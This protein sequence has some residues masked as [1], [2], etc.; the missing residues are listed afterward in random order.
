M[1]DKRGESGDSTEGISHAA[2]EVGGSNGGKVVNLPLT[3]LYEDLAQPLREV[4]ALCE[5]G[6]VDIYAV[7]CV[8]KEGLVSYSQGLEASVSITSLALL[9]SLLCALS[10]KVLHAMDEVVHDE[11]T[12]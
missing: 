10:Q 12:G 5:K 6:E 4:A 2:S 9:H 7:A 3:V 11:P 1:V 8:T